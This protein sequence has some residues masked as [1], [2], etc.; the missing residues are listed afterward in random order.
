LNYV[1]GM[2]IRRETSRR[3]SNWSEVIFYSVGLLI[4][5]LVEDEADLMSAW[6]AAA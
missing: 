4:C 3:G 2:N 1:H 6:W 5:P